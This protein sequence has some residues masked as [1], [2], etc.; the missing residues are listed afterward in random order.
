M[1]HPDF[2]KK[3]AENMDYHTRD[4]AF[5]K[6]MDEV[7]AKQRKADMDMYKLYVQD[8]S[9]LQAFMDTMKRMTGV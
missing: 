5:K 4:L 2:E 9:F 1:A 7:M 3:V 6:I 8:G